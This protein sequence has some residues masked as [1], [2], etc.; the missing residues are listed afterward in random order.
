MGNVGCW[1][2]DSDKVL[3]KWATSMY[4][5]SGVSASFTTPATD[6][7]LQRNPGA[8]GD[9]FGSATQELALSGIRVD[10]FDCGLNLQYSLVETA[11]YAPGRTDARL[12]DNPQYKICHGSVFLKFEVFSGSK[13]V[14]FSPLVPIFADE[15][16]LIDSATG[17][18]VLT[19]TRRGHWTPRDRC[20]AYQKEWSLTVGAG[21]LAEPNNRWVLGDIVTVLAMRDEERTNEGLVKMTQSEMTT[22]TVAGVLFVGGALL[23]ACLWGFFVAFLRTPMT[24]MCIRLEDTVF[25]MT[26]Y[27]NSYYY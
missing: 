14:A 4:S 5:V 27:K 16:T 11:M 18:T 8:V 21:K 12:C 17:S 9:S 23:L 25:P 24:R 3:L 19:A 2:D 10:F 6:L 7:D 22:W 1:R 15:Y 26:M 13:V 20:P